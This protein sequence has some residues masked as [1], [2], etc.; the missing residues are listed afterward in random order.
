MHSRIR[1]PYRI[2]VRKPERRDHLENLGTDEK[3]ILKWIVRVIRL[4]N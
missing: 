2:V 3:K 1:H 4:S